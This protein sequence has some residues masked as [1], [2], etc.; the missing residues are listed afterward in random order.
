MNNTF[1]NLSLSQTE[2]IEAFSL[3]GT[4]P[5]KL[6]SVIERNIPDNKRENLKETLEKATSMSSDAIKYYDEEL[7]EC[8]CIDD[9]VKYK[10]VSTGI[11]NRSGRMI[12]ASFRKSE[13]TR[14]WIMFFIA[15]FNKTMNNIKLPDNKLKRDKEV[16][17]EI[18]VSA[19]ESRS[20]EASVNSKTI[21]NKRVADEIYNEL[22]IKKGWDKFGD[23]SIIES[24]LT[25]IE[26]KILSGCS[27]DAVAYNS[28]YS[29]VVY[30]TGLLSKYGDD[31]LVMKNVGNGATRGLHGSSMVNSRTELVEN[32]FD[33]NVKVDAFKMYD[34]I[35]EL[36]FTAKIDDFDM[37]NRNHMKHVIEE[38][39][40]RFPERVRNLGTEV[41]YGR[42]VD[43]IELSLKIAEHDCRW[44]MPIYFP[45]KNMI[46]Y[47][48]PYYINNNVSN[49]QAELAILVSKRK[50]FWEVS[51]IISVDEAYKDA[52][53]VTNVS[54]SWV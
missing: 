18:K 3:F 10:V 42:L 16:S 45:E 12:Y 32:G 47:A 49:G 1:E 34:D 4:V 20:T 26:K 35:N 41:L 46:S 23:S 50:L 11:A 52:M 30:N 39:A 54:A 5:E 19:Q 6:A 53:C 29:K 9:N 25:M 2:I 8:L 43:S 33:K 24:Y 38:R 13:T 28:D 17:T 48:F 37:S 21:S 31:I 27:S 15:D 44:I 7:N 36:I 22:L 51:T 40:D 14:E